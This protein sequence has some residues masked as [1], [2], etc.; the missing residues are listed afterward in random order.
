MRSTDEQPWAVVGWDTFEGREYPLSR[1][2][3]ESEAREA[4]RKQLIE[5]AREQPSETSGGQDGIQ[6]RIYITGPEGIRY[7]LL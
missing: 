7:R 2:S 4:G 5:I 1:H 3:T 6:D